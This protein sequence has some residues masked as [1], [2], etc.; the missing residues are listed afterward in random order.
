ML[1]FFSHRWIQLVQVINDQMDRVVY[2]DS[3]KLLVVIL[4]L[5]HAQLVK[6][7][8]GEMVVWAQ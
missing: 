2:A 3:I 5:L 1:L 6:H 7:F 8:F 4:V